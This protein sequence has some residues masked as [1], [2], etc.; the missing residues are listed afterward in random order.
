MDLDAGEHVVVLDA[1]TLG[2]RDPY[3]GN[4]QEA[5][6]FGAYIIDVEEVP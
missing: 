3:G 4:T 6:V 1:L 5:R 2:Y